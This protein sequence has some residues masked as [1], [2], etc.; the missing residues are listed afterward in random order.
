MPEVNIKRTK[1][2]KHWLKKSITNLNTTANNVE[3]FVTQT[4]FLNDINEK[5]QGYR[6]KVDLYGQFYAVLAEH[7]SKV[8]KEDLDH[9]KEATTAITTLTNL[10]QAVENSQEQ[11]NEKFRKQLD[12]LIPVL[13]NEIDTLTME[14]ED[15][16]YLDKNSN[17]DQM[18]EELT[19]KKE[20]FEELESRSARYN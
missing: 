19:A 10:V 3:E 12:S 17:I 7:G 13:T 5:L 4:G 11:Q 1:E 20:R 8:K 6:D 14:Q 18:I 15:P 16:C 9:H 2:A